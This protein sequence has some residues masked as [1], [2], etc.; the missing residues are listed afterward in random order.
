[1]E[2]P[3]YR[4][5]DLV[6]TEHLAGGL[7]LVK[8]RLDDETLASAGSNEVDDLHGVVLLPVAVDSAHTL[9]EAGR[10]PR[11]V[12]VDHDPAE[13]EVDAFRG[14]I[15]ADHEPHTA[16]VVR[17]AK[18]LNMLLS[19]RVV[20]PA[21]DLGD[22]LG[23]AHATETLDQVVERVSMLGENDELLSREARKSQHFPELVKLGLRPLLV[24]SPG[25]ISQGAD[26][27]PFDEKV[28]QGSGDVAGE[29]TILADF[30]LLTAALDRFLVSRLRVENVVFLGKASLQ[31]D[32]LLFRQHA[33]LNLS[34]QFVELADPAFEG[35]QERVGG[36]GHAA[37]EHAHG[38]P[39]GRAVQELGAVVDV[40]HVIGR[41]VVQRLLADRPLGQVITQRVGNP[42]WIEGLAIEVDH[43]LF[44]AADEMGLPSL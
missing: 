32:E 20:H 43:L 3:A 30:A 24:D 11:N 6:V 44:G 4:V 13:L 1:M 40:P 12:E 28:G 42:R 31:D 26:L 25:E 33:L 22:L 9:L 35:S 37:L 36:T 17:Q 19:F 16:G 27:L 41:L 18:S 23:V 7:E 39:C 10:V 5:K 15:G 2:E 29:Q 14:S 34:N 21:V 38:Q 8:H